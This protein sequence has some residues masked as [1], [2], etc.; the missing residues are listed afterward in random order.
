MGLW[1]KNWENLSDD[2][3]HRRNRT[4]GTRDLVMSDE[5]VQ[6]EALCE[7]EI[8]LN[9]NN[10]SLTDFKPMPFPDMSK[11]RNNYNRLI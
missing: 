3:Q 11:F 10:K 7:I 9:K 4:L 1:N 8:I 6:N 2:I 5:E